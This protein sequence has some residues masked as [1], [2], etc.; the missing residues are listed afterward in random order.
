MLP[1]LRLAVCAVSLLLAAPALAG[2]EGAHDL[3]GVDEVTA[4]LTLDPAS[5]R[6]TLARDRSGTRAKLRFRVEYSAQLTG[7]RR[8]Q[9]RGALSWT[10]PRAAL[11]GDWPA[12]LP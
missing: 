5:L 1:L 7:G 10:V 6:F 11:V 12:A 2:L 4:L 8:R 3:Y 9:V